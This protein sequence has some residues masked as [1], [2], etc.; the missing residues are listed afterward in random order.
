MS[1]PKITKMKRIISIM[2]IAAAAA[3]PAMVSAQNTYSG[4]F[5]DNY[6]YGYEMNPAFGNNSNYVS[7]PAL[8]N[9]NLSMRGTLHLSSVVFNREIDGVNKTVL[10]TNPNVSVADAMKG[11]KSNNRLATYD[12]IEIMSAGFKAWGGYNTINIS[13]VANVDA[14][15]PGSFFRLAKEGITNRTY[16]IKDLRAHAEAYG[17]IALNHSRDI[18][19]VPGLRIGAAIKFMLGVGAIDAQ[20]NRAEL[21]LGTDNWIARTNADIYASVKGLT[22]KTKTYEPKQPGPG[23]EPYDYVSG[24]DLDGFGLSGFGMGFDLGAQYKW[25]DFNFTLAVVDLGFMNWGKTQWASTDGTREVETDAFTFNFDDKTDNSFDNE[26]DR[27]TDNFSKLYNLK[28]MGEKSGLTRSLR[29]TVNVGVEYALPYYRKLKFG[30]MNS[31]CIA[32]PYTWTQFRLS[33]NVA[34]V[35]VFSAT[36]NVAYGTYGFDFGWM[37]NLHTQKGFNLF[38]GM[39]HTLGK[40]AKQGIPLNSNASLNF[41]INFPF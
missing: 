28:D 41:G 25:R 8:G 26:L 34:P 7:M 19:Q 21:E 37:L 27:L 30:L 9:L 32:G 40:L 36:A 15:L 3:V 13:A 24:A 18:K 20:F 5:L 16:D 6:T 17:Q 29:T 1:D 4:Y 10:F 39:D 14:S 35:K 38:V 11:I 22:Y 31:T 12:K 33:A 23:N 2:T